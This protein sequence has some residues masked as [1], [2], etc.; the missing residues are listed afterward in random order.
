M[1]VRN[2]GV[3]ACSWLPLVGIATAQPSDTPNCGSFT[4]YGTVESRAFVDLGEEGATAGDQR[5]GRYILFDESGTELGVMHFAG[6]VMPPWQ[7]AESP[8]MNTL[9]FRF[10]GGTVVATSVVGLPEMA[11]VAVGPDLNLQYAVTGGT[12]VYSRAAGTLSSRSVEG[13]RRAMTFELTCGD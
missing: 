13:D 12:G 5:V 11:D 1:H 6:V 9:H 4:V 3:A 8:L 10:A 7:S 2:I